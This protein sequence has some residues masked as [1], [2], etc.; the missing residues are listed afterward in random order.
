MLAFSVKCI[1]YQNVMRLKIFHF[2]QDL[3]RFLQKMQF[4]QETQLLQIFARF[5]KELQVFCKTFAN[6]SFCK[7]FA[8]VVLIARFLQDFLQKMFFLWTRA[9]FSWH[10]PMFSKKDSSLVK[11]YKV[12]RQNVDCSYRKGTLLYFHLKLDRQTSW[13]YCLLDKRLLPFFRSLNV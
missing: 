12:I 7:K 10:V 2:L 8:K 3:A 1:I 6:C 13:N 5:E 4:L 11:Q 9:K